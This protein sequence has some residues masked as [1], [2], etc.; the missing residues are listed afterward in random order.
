LGNDRGA[1]PRNGQFLGG[2]PGKSVLGKKKAL[3]QVVK[4]SF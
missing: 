3:G 4:K 2:S 1:E